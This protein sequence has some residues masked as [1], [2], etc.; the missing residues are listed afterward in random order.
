MLLELEEANM[1]IVTAFEDEEVDIED[2]TEEDNN[3][4]DSV[5]ENDD[6]IVS[7]FLIPLLI[8]LV[9]STIVLTS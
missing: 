6:D 7:D 5:D 9:F 3:E 4:T 8:F 2:E 1:D